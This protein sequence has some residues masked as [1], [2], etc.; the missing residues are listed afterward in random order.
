MAVKK[1]KV[2][3]K[4]KRVARKILPRSKRTKKTILKKLKK[5]PLRV[6]QL[7]KETVVGRVTHYFPHVNA[8][9]IKITK[10]SIKLGDN[11][12]IKGHTT[13]FTQLA[14]SLQIDRMPVKEA[15]K[16]QEIGLSVSSRV[17]SNDLVCKVK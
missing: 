8:A 11:L 6:K 10:D 3:K 15:K 1:K 16:G 17:R 5:K 2:V 4:T 9:V 12:H 13:D 7:T 14:D